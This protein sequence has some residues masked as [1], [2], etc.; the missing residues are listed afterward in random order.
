[1]K[2]NL[3]AAAVA[4]AVAASIAG[5]A[6]ADDNRRYEEW[7]DPNSG[8]IVYKTPEHT[9]KLVKELRQLLRAGR[10]DRAASPRFMDDIEKALNRHRKAD[11]ALIRESNQAVA[12]APKPQPKPSSVANIEDDFSDGNFTR[13]PEWKLVRGEFFVARGGRLFSF[14]QPQAQRPKNDAEAIAQIF[15]TLLGNQNRNQSERGSAEPAAIFLP[16]LITNSFEIQT[17]LMSDERTG[18]VLELGVYQGSDGENGYRLQFNNGKVRMIR[19]GRTTVVLGEADFDF[20]PR[21][22]GRPG[23]YQVRWNRIS[24][25]RMQVFING[26][27][28]MTV[29]D[30]GFRD[31]WDGFRFVN[32]EGRHAMDAIR[33]TMTRR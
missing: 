2:R 16:G 29:N 15:G 20:P 21:V 30:R 10:R 3:I 32:A 17:Q 28:Y 33:I 4:A 7:R 13:N 22:S 26:A 19:V 9:E 18:G 12:P 31:D 1:M 11:N 25:G 27:G 14:V 6:A 24:S 5:P 8:E 23:T